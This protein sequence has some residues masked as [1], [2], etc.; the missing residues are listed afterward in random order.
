MDFEQGGQHLTERVETA[1]IAPIKP[2]IDLSVMPEKLQS[3][4]KDV[5]FAG[6]TKQLLLCSRFSTMRTLLDA[7]GKLKLSLVPR[8]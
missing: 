2:Y 3:M 5:S 1:L 7:K 4:L 6:A 8:I